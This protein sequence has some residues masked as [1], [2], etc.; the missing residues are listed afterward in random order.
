MEGGSGENER[1]D[2]SLTVKA[3][4]KLSP[5]ES[6]RFEL[7]RVH[8]TAR[9]EGSHRPGG[10]RVRVCR[11]FSSIFLLREEG[12]SGDRRKRKEKGGK[13]KGKTNPH[14]VQR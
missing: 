6:F 10:G 2:P 1:L 8:S 11:K 14:G 3:R 9:R 4:A 12:R 13:E 7:H 5:A